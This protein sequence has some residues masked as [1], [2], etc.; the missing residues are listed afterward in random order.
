MLQKSMEGMM[1]KRATD[2]TEVSEKRKAKSN[3]NNNKKKK[4]FSN[5]RKKMEATMK[6]CGVISTRRSIPTIV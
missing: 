5:S 6:G 3:N 1:K 2:M 4:K